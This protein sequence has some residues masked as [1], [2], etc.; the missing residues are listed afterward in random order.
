MP[1]A[2]ERE[3]T[4]TEVTQAYVE[5]QYR[6]HLRAVYN[7]CLMLGG[8][9]AQWAR[10]AAHDVFV[11]FLECRDQIDPRRNVRAWLCSVAYHVCLDR[12]RRERGI[13]SRVR[14]VLELGADA[15]PVP[16]DRVVAAQRELAAVAEALESLPAKQRVVMVMKVLDGMTQTEIAEALGLSKG[17]VSKLLARALTHM[18]RLGLEVPA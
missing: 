11:R 4:P 10:D 13:W 3:V 14:R 12:L 18:K 2:A 8:G 9:R 5:E 16:P 1:D 15:A 7:R 6:L 17:Y